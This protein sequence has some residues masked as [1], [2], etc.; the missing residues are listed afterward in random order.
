MIEKKE[1]VIKGNTYGLILLPATKGV[2][3]LKA[4]LKV[5]GPAWAELNKQDQSSAMSGAIAALIENIDKVEVEALVN[6]LLLTA[7]KENKALIVDVEFAGKYDVMFL[8]L[9]EIFEFN[10]GSVFDLLASDE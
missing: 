10:F 1:V 3:V 4:V 7:T 5:L 9:K 2:S 6:N 8:L